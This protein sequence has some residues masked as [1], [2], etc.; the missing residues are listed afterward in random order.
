MAAALRVAPLRPLTFLVVAGLLASFLV[1]A[2]S[3]LSPVLGVGAVAALAYVALAL[4]HLPA[5]LALWVVTS[6]FEAVPALEPAVKASGLILVFA[7]LGSLHNRQA[8]VVAFVRR[9]AKLLLALF[10][11]LAWVTLS[12]TW[13]EQPHLGP[14]FLAWPVAIAVLIVV[15]TTVDSERRLRLV[16]GAF[17]FAAVASLLLGL[18][19][20]ETGLGSSLPSI[21]SAIND[22][23]RVQGGVGGANALAAGLV[24]ALALAGGLALTT[25]SRALRALLL[26][27]VAVLGLGVVATQSR[28][29][30]VALAA[31]ALVALVVFKARRGI[32][33]LFV[34]FAL[35]ATTFALVVS[36]D[37]SSCVTQRDERGGSGRIDTW[38]VAVRIAQDH[39]L[40]GVGLRNYHV[41]ALRYAGDLASLE[42]VTLLERKQYV[43][44]VYLEL[45]AE[46]G[47]VGLALYLVV[48]G[49]CLRAS[50][51]AIRRFEALGERS[52]ADLARSVVVATA[53]ALTALIFLSGPAISR[54]W[55]LLALGPAMLAIAARRGVEGSEQRASRARARLKSVR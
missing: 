17:V 45:L 55:I 25:R 47:L 42:T 15:A 7:W 27:A 18:G 13:S 46:L 26:A 20:G 8:Q 29:G 4:V 30:L 53:G 5:G 35:A 16:A 1:G 31:A 37:A 40:A 36:P 49:G 12:L 3:A 50:A 11:L 14:N 6:F 43:H 24:S 48:V 54:L 34:A 9:H 2:A 33:L 51:V 39:P 21:G 41:H 32:V 52:L 19:G 28:G 22:A 44:N 23:G 38:R 10:A